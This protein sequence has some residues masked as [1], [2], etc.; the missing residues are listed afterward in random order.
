MLGC[1]GDAKSDALAKQH[2]AEVNCRT[3]QRL[4]ALEARQRT[5]PDAAHVTGQVDDPM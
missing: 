1:L 5:L 2:A 3:A 4:G